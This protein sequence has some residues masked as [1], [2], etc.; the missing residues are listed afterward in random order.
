MESAS[1]PNRTYIAVYHWFFFPKLFQV[2]TNVD[3]EASVIT[4]SAQNTSIVN[5]RAK[6]EG[7]WAEVS[8]TKMALVLKSFKP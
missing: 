8:S 2:I 7:R 6:P 4:E 5:T 1:Q 3:M